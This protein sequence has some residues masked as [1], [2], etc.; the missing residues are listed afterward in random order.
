M[1][2]NDFRGMASE[3]LKSSDL[4]NAPPKVEPSKEEPTS[5][6]A[7]KDTVVSP[8]TQSAAEPK[9]EP[10]I[11]SPR[12]ELKRQAEPASKMT[13]QK[14]GTIKIA[15]KG[16]PTEKS[17]DKF[18]KLIR[19]LVQEE[20]RERAQAFVEN[21]L[22]KESSLSELGRNAL[23]RYLEEEEEFLE[24]LKKQ[25]DRLRAKRDNR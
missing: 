1:A 10:Q 24:Q 3:R 13:E 23:L 16:R 8:D 25:H 22:S 5:G 9:H 17:E 2:K 4:F 20:D 21:P 14:S 11:S 19:V 7:D 15:K 6:K 12:P 18:D